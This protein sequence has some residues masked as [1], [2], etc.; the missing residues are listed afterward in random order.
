[1]ARNILQINSQR[2]EYD[3]YI[4]YNLIVI[5]LRTQLRQIQVVCL[6]PLKVDPILPFLVISKLK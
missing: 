5:R 6:H 3:F 1:M 4:K 2:L